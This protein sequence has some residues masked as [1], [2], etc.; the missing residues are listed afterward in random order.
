MNTPKLA[1]PGIAVSARATAAP[2]PYIITYPMFSH[3]AKPSETNTAYTTPSKRQLKCGEFQVRQ[4][5]TRYLKPSSDSPTITKNIQ[6][7]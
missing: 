6:K 5:S 1:W 2:R 4:R 3:S 7:P